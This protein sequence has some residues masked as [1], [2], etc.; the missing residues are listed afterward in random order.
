[1]LCQPGVGVM[2]TLL[3]YFS[4]ISLLFDLSMKGIGYPLYFPYLTYQLSTFPLLTL[5]S[6]ISR[7][8]DCDLF[9]VKKSE[10]QQGKTLVHVGTHKLQ[11]PLPHSQDRIINYSCRTKG[12]RGKRKT[13]LRDLILFSSENTLAYLANHKKLYLCELIWKYTIKGNCMYNT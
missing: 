1:M 13:K 8:R 6:A 3:F 2:Y 7:G 4:I 9:N 12:T 5:Y 11:F 10:K